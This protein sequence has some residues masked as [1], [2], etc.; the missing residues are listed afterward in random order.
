[1]KKILSC[2]LVFFLLTFVGCESKSYVLKNSVEEIESIEIVYAESSTAF[3]TLKKLSEDEKAD[4]LTKFQK[5]K[6]SSYYFGDPMS[7]SGRTI[8]I[9]YRNGNYEMICHYWAE[10]V[11]DGEIYFIKR[12][13]DEDEFNS[14]ID[15]Y[16]EWALHA[17]I[18][19]E[20]R[21]LGK[22]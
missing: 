13:C 11:K 9:T 15:F 4:F 5:L 8:K 22:V 14:F 16:M 21:K 19:M 12:N 6:F 7:V 2:V 20:Q 1:M 10:Y 18:C 3:S 17:D